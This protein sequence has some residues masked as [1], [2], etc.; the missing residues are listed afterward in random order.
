MSFPVGTWT[1]FK[2]GPAGAQQGALSL[3]TGSNNV[4]L[5]TLTIGGVSQSLTIVFDDSSQQIAFTT[6]AAP[7]NSAF[8][9]YQGWAFQP[10]DATVPAALLAGTFSPYS[11]GG[12]NAALSQFAW[13]AVGAPKPKE[14]KDIKDKDKDKE[15]KDKDKDHKDKEHKDSAK[16]LEKVAELQ[17]GSGGS[18]LT[19][20]QMLEQRLTLIEHQL[21]TGKSFIKPEERPAVGESALKS[22]GGDKGTT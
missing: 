15:Q 14:H 5:G 16:E 20:L 10:F 22:P 2:F 13:Y 19:A 18:G 6:A 8:E 12:P 7:V 4:P 3:S 1:I 21:A 9:V 11:P 17:M